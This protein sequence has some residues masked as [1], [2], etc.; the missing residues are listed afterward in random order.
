MNKQ[1]KETHSL[2]RLALARLISSSCS[3]FALSAAN[4]A[5]Y[6]KATTQQSAFHK[7]SHRHVYKSRTVYIT[8]PTH[9]IIQTRHM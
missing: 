1:N 9:E 5:L 7:Q 3:R 4:S 8:R 6:N 2:F